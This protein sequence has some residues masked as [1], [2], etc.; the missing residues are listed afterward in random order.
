MEEH[1]PQQ[2][3]GKSLDCFKTVNFCTY[4]TPIIVFFY[5]GRIFNQQSLLTEASSDRQIHPGVLSELFLFRFSKKKR[6]STKKSPLFIRQKCPFQSQTGRVL[7]QIIQP[8]LYFLFRL[9]C[10]LL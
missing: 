10:F 8:L 7:I 2:I 4:L 3:E 5:L 9:S 6:A 1:I